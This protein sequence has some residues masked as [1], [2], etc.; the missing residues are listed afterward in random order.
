MCQLNNSVSHV[1]GQRSAI[2]EY[3]SELVDS[4]GSCIGKQ[5]IFALKF[6]S[7]DILELVHC[8]VPK[9]D[10]KLPWMS[11]KKA[12]LARKKQ[13]RARSQLFM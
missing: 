4:T 12:W 10:K 3:T 9:I 5:I 8:L 2:D 13:E 1:V 6:L 11:V 7:C